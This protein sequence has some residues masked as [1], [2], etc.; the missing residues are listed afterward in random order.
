[1]PRLQA[2]F[3]ECCITPALGR[4]LSRHCPCCL[5]LILACGIPSTYYLPV[6]DMPAVLHQGSNHSPQ[7]QQGLVD[8]ACL[9]CARVLGT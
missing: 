6:W 7:R 5:F 2:A 3:K 8:G 9:T 1:M 4:L